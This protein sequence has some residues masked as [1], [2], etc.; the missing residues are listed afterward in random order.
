MVAI[1]IDMWSADVGKVSV[2]TICPLCNE[3][4]TVEGIDLEGFQKWTM[5]E[6]IHS[7]LPDLTGPQRETLMSGLHSKCF[8][9]W[10]PPDE[11]HDWDPTFRPPGAEQ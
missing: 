5:G 11:D 2:K 9:T 7:A 3:I 10:Y 1:F 6:M 8:D 4:A